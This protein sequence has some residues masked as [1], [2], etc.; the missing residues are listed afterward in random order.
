MSAVTV[1]LLG[2]ALLIVLIFIGMPIAWSLAI[3]GFF[4][5]LVLMPVETALYS[6]FSLPWMKADSYL[7]SVIPLFIFMGALAFEAG[8]G[9][10]AYDF[11]YRWFGW[12]PGGLAIATALTGAAFAA[13]SGSSVA[14]AATVGKVA[15][16]E[17]EKHGYD[18]SLATG[19]VAACGTLGVLIPPSIILVVYGIVTELSIGKLFIAG[20]LPGFLSVIIYS[21]MIIVRAKVNPSL[22]PPG[23]RASWGVRVRSLYG[24]WSIVLLLLIVLGGI[25]FGIFTPTEAAAVGVLAA[26]MILLIRA[27]ERG[28][29]FWQAFRDTVSTVGMIFLV[30][31]GVSIFVVFMAVSTIPA[32]TAE[33]LVNLPLPIP[34]VFGLIIVMYI[35]L[36]M[37]LD[38]LGIIFI[39]MPI[40]YPAILAMGYDGIWFGIIIT[41][42]IENGLITPPVGINVY[43]VKSITPNVP[44]ED[45]FKGILW[46]CVMDWVTLIILIVFPQI[47]L[48]LPS[49]MM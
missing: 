3:T 34:V 46:F 49:T 33:F 10:D 12:L 7:L 41:V 17:M 24:L 22:A 31:A 15:I 36:G 9:K 27:R 26:A 47:S 19:S 1:G 25:Y 21:G 4:G 43:I 35:P 30:I 8:V 29:A 37:F 39:T 13:V 42:L 38:P 28:K 11:A 44:I 14:T 16:P 32:K 48:W 20:I 23:E 2:I 18:A 5:L 40:I 45:I 6:L